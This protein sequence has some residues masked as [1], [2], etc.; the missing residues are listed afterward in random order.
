MAS[1]QQL[2][3]IRRRYGALRAP[4]LP[5][6]R[7]SAAQL[8]MPQTG[9]LIRPP[10]FTQEMPTFLGGTD[11]TK[12]TNRVNRQIAAQSSYVRSIAELPF[13]TGSWGWNRRRTEQAI[14]YLQGWQTRADRMRKF[15]VEDVLS[16]AWYRQGGLHARH[17]MERIWPTKGHHDYERRWEE[18]YQPPLTRR[19]LSTDWRS[20]IGYDDP[21]T[22]RPRFGKPQFTPQVRSALEKA[23]D[24]QL[25]WERLAVLQESGVRMDAAYADP[26][27]REWAFESPDKPY[28]LALE[29]YRGALEQHQ[30]EAKARLEAPRLRA[31]EV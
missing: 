4:G 11:P 28:N 31:G 3:Q 22:F 13:G 18:G 16:G 15:K 26:A 5:A 20:D 8:A 10:G 6:P 23:R 27:L 24:P 2:A 29:Q 17:K 30:M 1:L 12:W 25:A 7:Y 14:P 9:G 21:T 19:N